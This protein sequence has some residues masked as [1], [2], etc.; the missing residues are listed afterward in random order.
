MLSSSGCLIV[1]SPTQLIVEVYALK[2]IEQ[3]LI[4]SHPDRTISNMV[5]ERATQQKILVAVDFGRK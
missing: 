1:S 3:P 2:N 4:L 5:S